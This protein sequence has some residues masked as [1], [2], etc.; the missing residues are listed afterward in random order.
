MSSKVFFITGNT[1]K[2]EHIF[3]LSLNCQSHIGIDLDSV[4]FLRK[5]FSFISLTTNRSKTPC[6]SGADPAYKSD[7]V[8]GSWATP[9]Y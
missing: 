8:T 2:K 6:S 1:K 5:L 3:N 7:R 9:N 4:S